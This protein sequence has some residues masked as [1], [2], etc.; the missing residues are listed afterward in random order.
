MEENSVIVRPRFTD[1]I[2][3]LIP[4]KGA[5][6]F[7]VGAASNKI[8]EKVLG[9]ERDISRNEIRNLDKSEAAQLYE[10]LTGERVE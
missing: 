9:I 3:V 2:W 6:H 4:C 7:Y 5:G 8:H 10:L 1:T